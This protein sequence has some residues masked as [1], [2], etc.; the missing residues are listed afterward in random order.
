M[1]SSFVK[2]SPLTFFLLVF[3]LSFPLW[4]I[5]TMI[6]VKGLPLDIPVTDLIAAFTPLIAATI[7]VYKKEGHIGVKNLLKRVFDF[8]RIRQKIW[9]AAAIFLAPLIFLLIFLVLHLMRLPLPIEPY[10][11]FLKMPLLFICYPANTIRILLIECFS[12]KL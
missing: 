7:L 10:I 1:N 2:K 12:G 3:A 6:K 4:V 9:Y 5:E 8:S 11:P